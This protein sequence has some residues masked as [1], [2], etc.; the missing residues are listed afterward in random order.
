VTV[1]LRS[2]QRRSLGGIPSGV[3]DLSGLSCAWRSKSIGAFTC[4][5]RVSFLFGE[6]TSS[7]LDDSHRDI[8]CTVWSLVLD[9]HCTPRC[10]LAGRLEDDSHSGKRSDGGLQNGDVGRRTLTSQVV[11]KSL[12]GRV[13]LGG[14]RYS[15]V[16]FHGV[17]ADPSSGKLTAGAAAGFLVRGG[18]L[19]TSLAQH[20]KLFFST[21]WIPKICDPDGSS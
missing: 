2:P 6:T 10:T 5:P 14:E 12:G 17:V 9:W 7:S 19:A 11:R 8:L 16:S 1:C 4:V 15:G 21:S 3:Y 20:L 18:S 13:S